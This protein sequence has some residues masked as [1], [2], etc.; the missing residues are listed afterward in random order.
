MQ[1]FVNS[2]KDRIT[3]GDILFYN[4]S[5]NPEAFKLCVRHL[6]YAE[7]IGLGSLRKGFFTPNSNVSLVDFD[8]EEINIVSAPIKVVKLKYL[9]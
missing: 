1:N 7:H 8:K 6:S 9:S 4:T 3:K 5:G 2:I